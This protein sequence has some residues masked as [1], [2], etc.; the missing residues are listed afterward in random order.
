MR[1]EKCVVI[2]LYNYFHLDIRGIARV[3]FGGPSVYKCP[4]PRFLLYST[5]SKF[6]FG[7]FECFL[8]F[9]HSLFL[10]LSSCERRKRINGPP[11]I[12]LKTTASVRTYIWLAQVPSI[13]PSFAPILRNSA[14]AVGSPFLAKGRWGRCSPSVCTSPPLPRNSRF[15]TL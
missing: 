11:G 14:L 10:L 7:K 1:F 2:G 4:C 8:H 3:V 9:I 6:K 15:R 12:R 5:Y 13:T